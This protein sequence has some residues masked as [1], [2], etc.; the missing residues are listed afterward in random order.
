M[1][2]GLSYSRNIFQ[3][4]DSMIHTFELLLPVHYDE[5]QHLF[6]KNNINVAKFDYFE[7]AINKLNENIK[8][9]F[10]GYSV[11]WI[12]QVGNGNWNLHLKVDVPKIL[13]RGKITEKD[14]NLVESDIRK[15]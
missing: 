15:F 10:I 4:D 9:N 11:T 12:S 8:K 1:E 3:G 7:G 13:G 2:F 14:Y 6:R 5:V